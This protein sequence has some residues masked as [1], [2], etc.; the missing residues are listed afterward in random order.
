MLTHHDPDHDDTRLEQIGE[1]AAER[2]MLLG[3]EGTPELAREGE[4]IDVSH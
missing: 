3:G 2:W 1:V 4:A